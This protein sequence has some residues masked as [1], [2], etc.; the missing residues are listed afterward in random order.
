MLFKD[1]KEEKECYI[2]KRA[3][4]ASNLSD[5]KLKLEI[6]LK[7]FDLIKSKE[8]IKVFAS[9]I[10]TSFLLT[11]SGSIISFVALTISLI[12]DT[13]SNSLNKLALMGIIISVVFI[14]IAL[15]Y[16]VY[17]SFRKKGIIKNISL[18]EIELE[19]LLEEL[20][21]RKVK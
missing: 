19:I 8:E 18:M 20:N 16:F 5:D 1:K 6:Y 9:P 17:D 21:K 12:G 15:V 4:E 11:I 13:I 7:K 2:E 10:L 3:L 14:S